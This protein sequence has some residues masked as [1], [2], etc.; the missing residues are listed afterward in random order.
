VLTPRESGGVPEKPPNCTPHAGT[1]VQL[2]LGAPEGSGST[3]WWGRFV[4]LTLDATH[5]GAATETHDD[6][7]TAFVS[8][9][10]P[11]S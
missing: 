7:V 2:A 11:V 6:R 8:D 1:A 4:V 5:Q 3:A 9:P 10:N